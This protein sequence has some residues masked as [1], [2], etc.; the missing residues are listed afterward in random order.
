MLQFK[1]IVTKT[2]WSEKV[3]NI[4]K[5]K[6]HIPIKIVKISMKLKIMRIMLN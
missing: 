5:I 1:I 6:Y 2:Q 3:I 4:I